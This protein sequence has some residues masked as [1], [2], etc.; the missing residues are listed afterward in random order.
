LREHNRALVRQRD[1]LAAEL[2]QRDAV[3]LLNPVLEAQI[4]SAHAEAMRVAALNPV[5][6]PDDRYQQIPPR[7]GPPN[8]FGRLPMEHEWWTSHPEAA[9]RYFDCTCVPARADAF[10]NQQANAVRQSV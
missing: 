8:G 2:R 3:S 5:P 10:L 9:F 1:D 6:V 4:A 7:D